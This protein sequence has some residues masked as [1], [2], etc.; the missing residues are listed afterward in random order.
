MPFTGRRPAAVE[1]ETNEQ[2][3]LFCTYRTYVHTWAPWKPHTT[4]PLQIY[5][6]Y[7]LTNVFTVFMLGVL[8]TTVSA[9]SPRGLNT[10]QKT[11][12]KPMRA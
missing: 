8:P 10:R 7:A 11:M 3:W 12:L 1:T 4:T 9:H 5:T 6:Y 2:I